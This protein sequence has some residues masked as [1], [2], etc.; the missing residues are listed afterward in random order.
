[1]VRIT[2]YTN[3]C[4]RISSSTGANILCDP[5]VNPGA[6]LGSWFQWPPLPDNFEEKLL[7]E[8]CNGIYISHLHPDHYDPKFL[9]KF[10]KLHP[11]VPVYVAE[12]AH[13]WLKRSISAVVDKRTQVIEI[14]TLESIA[15]EDGFTIKVFAADTCN[16]NVCGSNVPCQAA[17][18]LRGIDSI[19]VFCADGI[20]VVNANDA[21]GVQ[22]VQRI[23]RNIGTAD[24]IMGHYGGASPFPQCFPDVAD[25]KEKAEEV[26]QAT[27]NTLISAADAIDA[28]MVLPFAGQY[29]LGGRLVG[30][31]STRATLPLDEA[32][33]LL[34]G[35]T[36]RQVISVQPGGSIDLTESWQDNPYREPSEEVRNRYIE[37]IE[38]AIFPYE[39]RSPDRWKEAG[40]Q[41]IN[42]AT[43][44]IKR[45]RLAGIAIENSFVIGDGTDFVTINLD[46]HGR[47]TNAKLGVNPAFKNVTTITMPTNLLR[48]LSTRKA[49]Y[50]G[51]T[52]MHWNQAD[53]GSHFIWRR[54]GLYDFASHSLLNFFGV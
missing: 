21:M 18:K 14:P 5:W 32:V 36:H 2:W 7:S 8:P 52:P 10:T 39:R 26:I 20:T 54:E 38:K 13:E 50:Q 53:V 24:L 44:V 47:N 6:F 11:D 41:L 49:G 28:K 19:G 4:V 37:Q 29:M 1:M 51:F 45:S 31:N 43:P 30:L 48:S 42:A 3:A 25:K 33:L 16:P 23:A 17:P 12:F 34:K 35:M 40:E 27:C 46:P 9:A 15:I 22:L